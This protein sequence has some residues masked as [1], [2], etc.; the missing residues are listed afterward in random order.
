MQGDPNSSQPRM[1]RASLSFGAWIKSFL[2]P[3]AASNFSHRTF[4]ARMLTTIPAQKVSPMPQVSQGSLSYTGTTAFDGTAG[5]L[6]CDAAYK[7][8]HKNVNQ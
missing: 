4:E 5:T 1:P 7:V 8:E 2:S 3:G 6:N